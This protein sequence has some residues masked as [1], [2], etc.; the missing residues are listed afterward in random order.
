[1]VFSL[2]FFFVLARLQEV[3]A[4]ALGVTSV[5]GDGGGLAFVGDQAAGI[6]C[7]LVGIMVYTGWVR[8]RDIWRR[9][10]QGDP[11]VANTLVRFRTAPWLMGLALLGI[12]IWWRMAGGGVTVALVEF[13]IYM[14]VQAV[15]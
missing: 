8:V 3:L 9:Q 15:I 7:A 5:G 11:A 1:M 4:G 6:S 2:W 12:V 14:F 10:A 13:G